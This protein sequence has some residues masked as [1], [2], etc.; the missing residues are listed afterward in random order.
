MFKVDKN[1]VVLVALLLLLKAC[2]SFFLEFLFLT[3]NK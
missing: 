3:L 2:H 1:F